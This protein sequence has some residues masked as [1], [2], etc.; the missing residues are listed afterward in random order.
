MAA[1]CAAVIAVMRKDGSRPAAAYHYVLT[2]LARRLTA[3][4]DQI[5]EPPPTDLEYHLPAGDRDDMNHLLAHLQRAG[6]G[7]ALRRAALLIEFKS[8]L[9]QTNWES[10]MI[11]NA[12][13]LMDYARSLEVEAKAAKEA[14]SA[15]MLERDLAWQKIA[16]AQATLAGDGLVPARDRA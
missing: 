6:R 13:P 8:T 16:L 2:D 9:S 15:M 3:L 11:E 12:E 1:D 4:A 7:A 14:R 5:G 10:Q